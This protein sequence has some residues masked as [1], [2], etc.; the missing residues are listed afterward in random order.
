MINEIELKLIDDKGN[1]S[2]AHIDYKGYMDMQTNHNVNMVV[3]VLNHMVLEY[4]SKGEMEIN[5]KKYPCVNHDADSWDEEEANKRMDVIGQNGNEGIH[6]DKETADT[7]YKKRMGEIDEEIM[8]RTQTRD[9][10]GEHIIFKSP[11]KH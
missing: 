6:Y 2:I 1:Y 9:A 7:F 8:K 4:E 10:I 3:D 11:H 5:T